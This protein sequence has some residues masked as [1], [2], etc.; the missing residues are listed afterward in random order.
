M[1]FGHLNYQIFTSYQSLHHNRCLHIPIMP[2]GTSLSPRGGTELPTS[3]I[4]SFLLVSLIC[5]K[6]EPFQENKVKASGICQGRGPPPQGHEQR[7]GRNGFRSLFSCQ[8]LSPPPAVTSPPSLTHRGLW[9]TKSWSQS[10]WTAAVC[11]QLCSARGSAPLRVQI[12]KTRQGRGGGPAT[13]RRH[14]EWGSA[15]STSAGDASWLSEHL[16]GSTIGCS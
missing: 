4:I 7:D 5:T 12:G 14:V 10:S 16:Q 6:D 13:P 15:S 9:R 1:Y 11:A 8:L 3:T 2:A